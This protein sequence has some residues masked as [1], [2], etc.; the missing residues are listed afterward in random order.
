VASP[1][2][3]A[4]TTEV[5]SSSDAS[6]AATQTTETTDDGR[7][8]PPADQSRYAK[9]VDDA[10]RSL[11][12]KIDA[13]PQPTDAASLETFMASVLP[14]VRK[15]IA[16]VSKLKPPTD[17]EEARR[18]RLFADGYRDIERA[19][20]RYLAA[21]RAGKPEAIQRALVEANAAGARTRTYAASL[22]VTACGG[23]TG[24]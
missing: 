10:C 4:A 22:D 16:A 8:A 1:P 23:Y 15:Q 9:Q 20:T 14:L 7:P 19:L 11:Q 5:A 13:L 6:T 18:A 12:D 3:T 21:I 24:G 17:N 2:T